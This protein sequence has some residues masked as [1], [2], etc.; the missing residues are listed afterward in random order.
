MIRRPPRSTLFPY[1]TLFRSQVQK[2]CVRVDRLECIAHLQ[3]EVAGGKGRARSEE[4]TSE[5]HPPC[6]AEGRLLL[7]KKT[8]LTDQPGTPVPP[9]GTEAADQGRTHT[10]HSS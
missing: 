10:Q 2:V 6:N 5:L 3:I 1:T 9:H 8:H 4:Q 7:Q